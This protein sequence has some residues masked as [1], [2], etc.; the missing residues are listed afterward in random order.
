[1]LLFHMAGVSFGGSWDR[2]DCSFGCAVSPAPFEPGK[3][4]ADDGLIPRT[5]VPFGLLVLPGECG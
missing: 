1:M 4:L 3:L 5:V 2:Q